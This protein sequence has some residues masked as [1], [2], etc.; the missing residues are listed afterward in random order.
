LN[1]KQVSIIGELLPKMIE[2]QGQGPVK[3]KII[4]RPNKPREE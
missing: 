1:D 2:S 4:I 3:K